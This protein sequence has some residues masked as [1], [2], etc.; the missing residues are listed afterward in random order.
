[1]KVRF[2]GKE[3]IIKKELVLPIVSG[4]ILA[5]VLAGC[6]LSGASGGVIIEDGQAALRQQPE[7]SENDTAL[8]D[9]GVPGGAPVGHGNTPGAVDEAGEGDHSEGGAAG[10]AGEAK[11][12]GTGR[13]VCGQYG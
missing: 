9:T 5:G 3:A 6:F 1:M 10:A 8:R 2:F 13:R 4:L 11:R 12:L 7:T